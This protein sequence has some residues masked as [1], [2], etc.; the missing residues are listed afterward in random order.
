MLCDSKINTI[1]NIIA[2]A[3]ADAINFFRILKIKR[4]INKIENGITIDVPLFKLLI[5]H[6]KYSCKPD[7]SKN[8]EL[9][10]CKF[11]KTYITY[12]FN[13]VIKLMAT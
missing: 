13:I 7:T 5:I 12:R 11:T 3:I 6:S 2:I 8:K 1:A 10:F 4:I 9:G